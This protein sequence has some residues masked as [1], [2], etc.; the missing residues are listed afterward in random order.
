MAM[1][2]SCT[3]NPY[4][5]DKKASLNN[6]CSAGLGQLGLLHCWDLRRPSHGAWDATTLGV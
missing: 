3:N 2:S 6:L 4:I 1:H 5:L